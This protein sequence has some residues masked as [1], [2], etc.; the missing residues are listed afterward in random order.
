MAK[1]PMNLGRLSRVDIKPNKDKTEFEYRL[2]FPERPLPVEFQSS[3][4]GAMLILHGLRQL[5]ATHKIPIPPGARPSEK[6]TLRVV[7]PDE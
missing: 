6:P 7:M 1:T 2:W 4:A 5:Q 3:A